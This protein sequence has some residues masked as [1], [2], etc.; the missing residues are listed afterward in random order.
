V[1]KRP[2]GRASTPTAYE[3]W[4]EEQAHKQ[5]RSAAKLRDDLMVL[6]LSKLPALPT[7]DL[8]EVNDLIDALMLAR[9]LKPTL[10]G[11]P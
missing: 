11:R 5:R 2:R 6:I 4:V 1:P 10:P 3:R 7:A 8:N 9:L